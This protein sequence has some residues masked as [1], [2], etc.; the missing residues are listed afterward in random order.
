[1]ELVD[2]LYI[3]NDD[4]HIKFEFHLSWLALKLSLSI[5]AMLA[6]ENLIDL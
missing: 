5:P 2:G 6:D 4:H 3:S 1:M